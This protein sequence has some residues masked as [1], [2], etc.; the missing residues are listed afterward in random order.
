MS[1]VQA[2]SRWHVPAADSFRGP[3]FRF[4]ILDHQELGERKKTQLH[5]ISIDR[6]ARL[7]TNGR[8]DFR[9]IFRRDP[10]VALRYVGE[11]YT[12]IIL[13]PALHQH[14]C[15]SSTLWKARAVHGGKDGGAER[16]ACPSE[17]G[18]T[19]G[20]VPGT[21]FPPRQQKRC[22]GRNRPDPEIGSRGS[23]R[24]RRCRRTQESAGP[25]EPAGIF[26]AYGDRVKRC[27]CLPSDLNSDQSYG[28]GI[29]TDGSQAS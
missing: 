11:L 5:A 9:K 18:R 4:Q 3:V 1:S 12:E 8:P 16:G 7:A 19:A 27:H 10:L 6:P 23:R 14:H 21:P 24:S 20:A 28:G 17:K 13:K 25:T 29:S 22:S 15:R 2:R 26:D